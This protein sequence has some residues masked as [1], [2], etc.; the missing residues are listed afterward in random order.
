MIRDTATTHSNRS[1]LD[2]Y[3]ILVQQKMKV[4]YRRHMLMDLIIPAVMIFAGSYACTVDF[5]AD[6]KPARLLSPLGFPKNVTLF[7][8]N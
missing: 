3:K 8:N 7:Y 4:N 6:L 1:S 2:H 5:V